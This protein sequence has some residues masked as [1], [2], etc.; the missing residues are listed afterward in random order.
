MDLSQFYIINH[1]ALISSLHIIKSFMM[2]FSNK[3]MLFLHSMEMTLIRD[4]SF[5]IQEI[6]LSI[7]DWYRL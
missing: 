3:M 1:T 2:P 6:L 5:M 7:L 4:F